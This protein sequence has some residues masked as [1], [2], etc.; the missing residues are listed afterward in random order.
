MLYEVITH[1]EYRL[2]RDTWEIKANSFELGYTHPLQDGLI[3]E[4]KIRSYSQA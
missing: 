1:G 4:G 2:Y 3:L